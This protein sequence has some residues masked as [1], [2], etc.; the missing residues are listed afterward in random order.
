MQ[1][2]EAWT[3]VFT[4]QLHLQPYQ[5]KFKKKEKSHLNGNDNLLLEW[6]KHKL[7]INESQQLWSQKG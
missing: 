6:E 4:F 7:A 5:R 1:P 3:K 2:A